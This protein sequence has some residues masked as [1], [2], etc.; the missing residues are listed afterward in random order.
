[1]P[2]T[3][4]VF[5]LMRHSK[6]TLFVGILCEIPPPDHPHGAISWPPNA[7]SSDFGCLSLDNSSFQQFNDSRRNQNESLLPRIALRNGEVLRPP[8]PAETRGTAV[9]RSASGIHPLPAGIRLRLRRARP[10]P[11]AAA[12]SARPLGDE[13]HRCPRAA[14]VGLFGSQGQAAG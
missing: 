3:Q 4:T 6:E 7:Y 13:S 14:A 5:G 2:A 1:M 10:G 12:S 11:S 9:S 8:F